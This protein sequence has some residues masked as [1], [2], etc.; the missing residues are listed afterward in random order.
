MAKKGLAS[1][2][3][4][5]FHL[6]ELPEKLGIDP[7]LAGLLHMACFMELSGEDAV[8]FDESVSALEVMSSY[9]QRLTRARCN[10]IEEQLRRVASYAKRHGWEARAAKFIRNLLQNAGK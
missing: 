4:G 3:Q 9:L 8:D 7:I 2:P 10:E 1:V 5:G 6:P